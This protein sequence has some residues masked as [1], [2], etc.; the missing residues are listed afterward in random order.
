MGESGSSVGSSSEGL[1]AVLVNEKG[2][3][4]RKF[5][6]D[7]SLDIPVEVSTLSLTEF[8]RYE[9]LEEKFRNALNE[10]GSMMERSED[11]IEEQE[12][13]EYQQADWDDPIAC[14]L[15]EILTNNLFATF[16]TAVKKIVEC[17]Y[18]EEVA[19]WAI[20]NSSLF[21]G[22]KDAV[23]NVL[24]GALSLLK[25]EKEF[26]M[27]KHPVFEGLQSLVDYT[28]LEM[29]HVLREVRPGLTIAEAMWCL[30]INDLNLV[31]ACVLEGGPTG[32]SC[33]QEAPGESPT[34]SQ[35]KSE[36][37]DTSQSDSNNLDNA[38][39]IM[40]HDQ[41][42]QPK[43][44]VT[45]SG[46]QL[47]TYK[48]SPGELASSGKESSLALQEAKGNFSGVGREHIQNS[49]QGM[50]VD[51]K[52]GGSRKGS[53]N[54]SKRDILR[55]KTFQFEKNYK[56]RMS[57]GAFKAKVA[58]WGSMVLDKSLKSQS[59][60]S[61]VVMKG[62]YSKLTTPAGTSSSLV[63]GNNHP[64]SNSQSGV[65]AS[66]VKDPVFALPAVYSKS[67]TSS[68][69][70]T[71]ACSKGEIN[72]SDTP[73]AT[74]YYA[75][76]PFDETLQKYVPQDDRDETILMLVPHMQALEKEIKGWMDWANE[77]VMQAARR[78]GKDQGELKMLR[79]EKEETEKFK[80]EKQT[81]EEST[82]KRLSEMEYA[83]SNATGQIEV[84]NCTVHRLG[85][86]NSV[87][88][89][90]M[91]A[92]KL[93]ALGSATNL[94]EAMQRE[95]ETLKKLQSWDAEKGLVLEQL[96]NLKRQ[97]AALN[98]RLEKAK[99]RKDQFKVCST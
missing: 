9:M 90:E 72:V 25:M 24:D 99:G 61:S 80:K 39:Q 13:E 38:K 5:L 8:P 76:I 14:Q 42:S 81:L 86:E 87:L 77:K 54:N 93:K 22:S 62:T 97:I 18:T 88:K 71:D 84:A 12:V 3:N 50:V 85:E 73:K 19:E 98:N 95:Q 6:S 16:C 58:A 44:P 49:S 47:S 83:L 70:D 48:P 63:E 59:G 28:L 45:G 10:L 11:T 66:I 30:L 32:G 46:D 2:R 57:K 40:P 96:T 53:S 69:P 56:G 92:A 89:K 31:N 27:P 15:E 60:S 65:P 52:P 79:Q 26:N 75:S 21:H 29:I 1:S 55:Q 64:S 74:D 17:G 23:S 41:S 34:L 37:S 20:L 68:V 91:E 4:K 7:L 35:S 51:E 78:L 33:S 43:A 36:T 94:Q 67:H 82:M